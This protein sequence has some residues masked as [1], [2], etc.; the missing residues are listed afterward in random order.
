MKEGSD[1]APSLA[2]V[3]AD[4]LAQ[5]AREAAGLEAT[6]P[7]QVAE[8]LAVDELLDYHAGRL[9]PE[10][11]DRVQDHLVA[12]RQ[13]TALLLDLE[14]LTRPDTREPGGTRDLAL[15][16]A[17]RELVGRLRAE[18]LPTLRLP[19]FVYPLA[20]SLLLAVV[21]LGSWVGVLHR[22]NDELRRGAASEANIP[23][24]QPEPQTR[25]APIE[26]SG[27]EAVAPNV[28][29]LGP[30]TPRFVLVFTPS[31]EY[32]EYE[33]EA[34]RSGRWQV[35]VRGLTLQEADGILTLAL[36][37]EALPPGDHALR[38][39]GRSEG[40]RTLLDEY[41]LRIVLAAR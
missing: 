37:R 11:Q 10:A 2:E 30:K 38:L 22:K 14:P 23:L 6:K 9:D 5:E 19:R 29:E 40:Q 28:I 25:A 32:E 1:P 3:L 34:S 41:A 31:P 8:H 4:V 12:C 16:A 33:V 20:A 27:A 15:V 35:L 17:W 21:G 18:E 26:G 39:Y 7:P 24:Y 13:C 36:S